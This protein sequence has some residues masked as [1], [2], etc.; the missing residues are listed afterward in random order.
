MA[1]A[2]PV[3]K[4]LYNGC[5]NCCFNNWKQ[6]RSSLQWC[7]KCKLV[8]YCSKECQHEHWFNVHKFQCKY[9]AKS[10]VCTQSVHD[11]ATC[12][13]CREE[14]EAGWEEMCRPDNPVLGCPWKCITI[15]A[16]GLPAFPLGEMSGQFVTKTDATLFLMLRI[17][18]KIKVTRH[19]AW[20]TDRKTQQQIFKMI[21]L[22]REECWMLCTIYGNTGP[23]LN[24]AV[25]SK[26]YEGVREFQK[27]IFKVSR[28]LEIK[29]NS[30]VNKFQ[31]WETLELLTGFLVLCFHEQNRN[32]AELV[33][34]PKLSEDLL[35]IRVT[36]TQFNCLWQQILDAL[37][38]GQVPFITLVEMLCSGK[39]EQ[40][41]YGCLKEVT[42]LYATFPKV[43]GYKRKGPVLV[44][45]NVRAV[46]CD[47]PMC[48]EIKE[49]I[50]V[51][52]SDLKALYTNKG[53]F[54]G[55]AFLCD[56]CGLPGTGGNMGHRCSRCL[57]KLYC[58]K[59]CRDLDWVVHKLVCKEGEV[60][61]KRKGSQLDRKMKTRA[62]AEINWV[63]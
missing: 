46:F 19:T 31:P 13:N 29:K 56:F 42:V 30:E 4:M 60:E 39:L 32:L 43:L 62:G 33:G 27:H 20:V 35:R 40:A 28:K 23:K 38:D 9:L 49:D 18:Y 51:Q 55:L 22:T 15:S 44:F 24:R 53:F 7:A 54:E 16:D 11:E 48:E 34:L 52:D 14:A 26:A 37:H 58:G 36:S 59:E 6:D 63:G 47:G 1:E 45:G 10:K 61:R 17:L 21:C 12:P 41:C 57:T 8:F 3:T 5:V 25:A 50:C 2:K